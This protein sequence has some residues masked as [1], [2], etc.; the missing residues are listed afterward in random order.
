MAAP[1][2]VT[3]VG[4]IN[5]DLFATVP[6]FLLPGETLTGTRFATDRGGKGANQATAAALAGAAV[7][8]VGRVG[9]DSFGDGALEAFRGL[10]IDTQHVGRDST[11]ATG[12]ALIVVEE[13]SGQNQIIVIPGANHALNPD[14]VRGASTL[15][16]ES[17]VV[18]CQLEVPTECVVEAFR[19]AKGVDNGPITILNPA[20]AAPI[21][22]ELLELCDM[23]AP[24]ETEL[25]LLTGLPVVSD[26]ELVAAAKVLLERGVRGHV[27]VTL[28][29]RGALVVARGS[30]SNVMFVPAPKVEAVDTSGA[31]DAFIGAFA[32]LTGDGKTVEEA[33][34]L[35]VG[36]ASLSVTRRGTQSSYPGREEMLELLK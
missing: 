5:V 4:S 1:V 28:G 11:T 33:A 35:A 19:I 15:L 22:D 17:K 24:N 36:V 29:S 25:E 16:R 27:V 9:N 32:R 30:E 20:P 31:G 14:H 2:P 10:G 13:R 7:S 6:R 12:T 23:V 21:P 26:N 8:F 3:V 34:K 18:V